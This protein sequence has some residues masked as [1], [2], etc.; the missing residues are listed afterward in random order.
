MFLRVLIW[1]KAYINECELI[2]G[3]L[4]EITV[5]RKKTEALQT[6]LFELIDKVI[7]KT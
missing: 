5:L 7:Q 4:S 3:F 1:C 2:S 6:K